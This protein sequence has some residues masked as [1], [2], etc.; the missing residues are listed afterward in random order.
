MSDD[1]T[2]TFDRETVIKNSAAMLRAQ[3]EGD[4][5]ACGGTDIYADS[6]PEVCDNT[7]I[8][9]IDC[10]DCDHSW[11]EVYSLTGIMSS[12]HSMHCPVP[13]LE[14]INVGFEWAASVFR[15]IDEFRALPEDYDNDDALTILYQIADIVEGGDQ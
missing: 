13:G 5:P 6:A 4:C 11:Y 1:K 14:D 9:V 12:Y 8:Q 10:M 7:C 15:L 2:T 3:F